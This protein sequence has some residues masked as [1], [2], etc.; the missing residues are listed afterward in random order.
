MEK[1]NY[2]LNV[3]A[4]IKEMTIYNFG[5]NRDSSQT[6]EMNNFAIFAENYKGDDPLLVFAF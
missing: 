1:F 3:K 2:M 5:S 4:Q 6:S